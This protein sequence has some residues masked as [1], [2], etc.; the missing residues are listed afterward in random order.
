MVVDK[1]N[2]VPDRYTSEHERARLGPVL[3]RLIGLTQL[4]LSHILIGLT[5]QLL[6][7]ILIG[8]MQLPL[9]LIFFLQA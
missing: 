9:F 7:H 1:W 4:L 5:Q 8:L 6:S 3:Y 2:R